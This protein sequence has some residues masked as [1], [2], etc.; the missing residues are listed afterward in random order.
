M[1]ALAPWEPCVALWLLLFST[2]SSRI[3]TLHSAIKQ[4]TLVCKRIESSCYY[5]RCLVSR[6]HLWPVKG[7][8]LLLF[9]PVCT[10]FLFTACHFADFLLHIGYFLFSHWLLCASL[11]VTRV[12]LHLFMVG[13]NIC[14]WFQ[15]FC[16][17][18]SSVYMR[19]VSLCDHFESLKG[20]CLSHFA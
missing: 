3:Q 18:V 12:M 17:T 20:S 6:K 10:I 9:A 4:K 2:K 15:L 8:P 16:L 13:G 5:F 7:S 1:F 11:C 14:V 19:S